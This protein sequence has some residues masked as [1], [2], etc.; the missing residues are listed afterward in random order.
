[1]GKSKSTSEKIDPQ[2]HIRK[3]FAGGTTGA[4]LG[5]A[6]A[7][8]VGAVLGGVVGT[9]IGNAAAKG[10]LPQAVKKAAKVTKLSK[11]KAQKVLAR[12]AK[13]GAARV[14]RS[15][16]KMARKIVAATKGKLRSA[17]KKSSSRPRS[18]KK[19]KR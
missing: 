6:V 4:L 13:T 2:I 5:A 16:R 18:P 1:M 3:E 17:A 7:G 10:P 14:K 12:G 8:P 19:S 9:V 15:G 11:V